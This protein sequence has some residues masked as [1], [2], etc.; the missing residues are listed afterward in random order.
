MNDPHDTQKHWL[1]FDQ[2][3]DEEV[4]RQAY[5]SLYDSDWVDPPAKTPRWQVALVWLSEPHL[6]ELSFQRAYV[7][8]EHI[9]GFRLGFKFSVNRS[10]VLFMTAVGSV[11]IEASY[12][13]R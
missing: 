12:A 11:E 1:A 3:T 8:A 6:Y 10:G 7:L 13:W 4:R 5:F 2:Q 9:P